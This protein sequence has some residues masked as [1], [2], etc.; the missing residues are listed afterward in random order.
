MPVLL[1]A[2]A[3]LLS[4]CATQPTAHRFPSHAPPPAFGAQRCHDCG[5]VEAIYRV[6]SARNHTGTGAVLG[7]VLGAIV[8]R[9][10]AEDSSE[11]RRNTAT[12]AGAA[13]GAVTGNVIERRMNEG[14][15]DVAVRMDD[16][17]RLTLNLPSL[18][19]GLHIGAYVRYDGRGL[20]PL[21]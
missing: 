19:H 1:G 13:A 11:G 4:A 18:P 5:T 21:R 16:G 7:G 6:Q 9:E 10:L 15:F 3:L 20:L 14:S 8:G 17:R 2:A 12:V